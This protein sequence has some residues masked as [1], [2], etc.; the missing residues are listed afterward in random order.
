MPSLEEIQRVLDEEAGNVTQAAKS[1][2]VHRN[3]LR[4]WLRKNGIKPANF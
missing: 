2:G 4:R 3:E 1:L